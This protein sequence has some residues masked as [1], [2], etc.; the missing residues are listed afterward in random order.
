MI[1]IDANLLIFAW[2]ES[3]PQHRQARIWIEEAFT[4]EEWIGIPWV[5]SWAFLRIVTNARV[6]P[7]AL[8]AEV[9]FGFVRRWLALPNVIALHPGPRHEELLRGLVV[10]GQ[11]TGS[12]VTDAVMA[13]MTIEQGATLATTDRDFSR[14]PGLSWFNPLE[15]AI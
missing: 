12:M 13:A 14:F 4:D 7:R 10:A 2:V 11:A 5:S 15:T 6:F 9:A 8:S 1:V 3:T